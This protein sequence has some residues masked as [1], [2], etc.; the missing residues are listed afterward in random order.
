MDKWVET[1]T[2]MMGEGEGIPKDG[3]SY[4]AWLP[5]LGHG[6]VY[7]DGSQ[8]WYRYSH[9]RLSYNFYSSDGMKWMDEMGVWHEI[10]QD[11]DK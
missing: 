10:G 4:L 11:K 3:R 2:Q 1:L 9:E 5:G 7:W 8:G 6:F